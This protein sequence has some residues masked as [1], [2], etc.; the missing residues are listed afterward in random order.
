MRKSITQW[1]L[2]VIDGTPNLRISKFF[3]VFDV[4]VIKWHPK[5]EGMVYMRSLNNFLAQFYDE[6]LLFFVV[7]GYCAIFLFCKRLW[8]Y[9]WKIIKLF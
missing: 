1:L 9:F 2:S 6:I 4:V 5:H 7:M 8:R 3:T